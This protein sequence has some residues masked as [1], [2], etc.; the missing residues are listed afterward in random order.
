MSSRAVKKIS[1]GS[2]VV[3]TMRKESA[4][5]NFIYSSWLK[6]Y[7]SSKDNV[8]KRDYFKTETAKI[9]D[10]LSREGAKVLMAVSVD[11]ENLIFGYVV[12]EI[13]PKVNYLHYIYVKQVFR[14]LG[15][16]RALVGEV[17]EL[18]KEHRFLAERI[19]ARGALV[20]A[21]ERYL[22]NFV[23]EK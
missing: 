18:T 8:E 4:D 6:S 20:K 12:A 7:L 16:A 3:R 14:E 10:V 17:I 5:L 23:G 19:P 2:V 22:I 1:G 11:D 9:D 21:A 15:I 13:L